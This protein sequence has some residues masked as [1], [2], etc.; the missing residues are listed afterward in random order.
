MLNIIGT[1][2]IG[3]LMGAVIYYSWTRPKRNYESKG[4]ALGTIRAAQTIMIAGV[5]L[6]IIGIIGSLAK[7]F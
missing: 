6:V 4:G 1:G 2:L 5:A 3:I 7:L